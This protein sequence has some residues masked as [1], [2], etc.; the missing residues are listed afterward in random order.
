[1]QLN[2]WPGTIVTAGN[3]VNVDLEPASL[4]VVGI[5][6]GTPALVAAVCDR[7]GVA[8]PG[9]YS[10]CL[11]TSFYPGYLGSVNGMGTPLFDGQWQGVVKGRLNLFTPQGAAPGAHHFITLLDSQPA[12][13]QSTIGHRPLAS[14]ND[15]YIGDDAASAITAGR[16]SFGSP[17]SISHYIANTGDGSSW[18]ERLTSAKKEFNVAVQFDSTVSIPGT[19]NGC[20]RFVSGVIGSFGSPCI[21]YPVATGTKVVT[22]NA[23]GWDTPLGISGAGTSVLTVTGTPPGA[24]AAWCGDG[25]SGATGTGC[26]TG[27]GNVSNVSTPVNLQMAQWT[28]ATQIQGISLNG[29][30]APAGTTSPTF[31]TPILGVAAA[32]SLN[33]L[34]LTAPASGA[35]LTLLNGKVFTVNSTLTLAGTDSTVMTFPSTSATIARTDAANT[36]TGHQ[37]LE[38]VTSTGATGTGKF[39]FSDSPAFTTAVTGITA[40]MVGL[41][42]VTND[43]QTKLGVVPNTPP[44]AGGLLI[45]NAVGTAYASGAMGQDATLASNGY[46]T[47]TGLRAHAIPSLTAGYLNY[48]GS[49]WL[50]TNPFLNA[51][52]TGTFTTPI[53]GGGVQ[54]VQIDNN[55][56]LTGTGQAPGGGGGGGGAG[57]VANGNVNSFGVYAVTGTTISPS[58]GA[59]MDGSGNANFTSVTGGSSP[60]TMCTGF[61]CM[62]W[63]EGSIVGFAGTAGVDAFLFDSATH[64]VWLNLNGANG[65]APF[66]S[67]MNLSQVGV[68]QM[69]ATGTPSSSTFLR[70]DNTWATAG[71]GSMSWPAT[72]GIE[73]C[74]GTPCTAYGTSLTA[75]A[76]TIVGTTDTQ[77][78]TNKT[79]DGVTPTTM[80]YVDP[81]SSIQTQLNSK[82]A[83]NAANT[84]STGLQ[85]FAS[86]TMSLPASA[87]Y[88]PTTAGLVG[89]DTTNARQVLGN[90]TNTSYPTWMITAPTTLHLAEFN[91]TLIYRKN[92]NPFRK[93]LGQTGV[94]GGELA[95]RSKW[96]KVCA[97]AYRATGFS[98]RT[99]CMN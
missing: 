77:A 97:N 54:G 81:A 69:S 65:G 64:H 24:G 16:L 20:A 88:A 19:T 36:F 38:G 23:T 99:Q 1:M 7:G 43:A 49:A 45:G 13:T 25:T 76:G 90:G 84:Y 82:V 68:S 31:V 11:G 5:P 51:V 3:T 73:V 83:N 80:G 85:S 59:G 60:P 35:T 66:D 4:V 56:V 17:V 46:L 34:T 57:T 37:T 61:P 70:G 8:S 33:K 92:K 26:T 79:V 9:G 18:L 15:V 78:L 41:G 89:Y 28:T 14:A 95:N 47:V 72:P 53:T 10:T 50:L 40:T 39:V 21:T 71:S 2:F 67:L 86:A 91:G 44:A 27:T 94:F 6:Q 87:A 96:E 29:T 74:T 75:P 98:R 22:A 32:T 42:S 12:L 63:G 62:A 55:G 93:R 30:G 58:V 52:F 48:S